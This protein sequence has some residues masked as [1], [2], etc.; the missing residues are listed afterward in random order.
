MQHNKCKKPSCCW[1][2]RHMAPNPSTWRS[3]SSNK[4]MCPMATPG[5]QIGCANVYGQFHIPFSS[6]ESLK[7]DKSHLSSQLFAI[8]RFTNAN[9]TCWVALNL[10]GSGNTFW[11]E[12]DGESIPTATH[13]SSPMPDPS[14]TLTILSDIGIS[15][16]GHE[17]GSGNKIWTETDG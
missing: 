11:T 1:D 16:V 9:S 8:L 17:T 6:W 2:G 13:T 3:R 10:T 15:N 5:A 14:M 12:I 7:Y 4:S